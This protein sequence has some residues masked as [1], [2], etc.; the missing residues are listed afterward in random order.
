LD[1]I[2]AQNLDLGKNKAAALEEYRKFLTKHTASPR[3]PEVSEKI[4][5]LLAN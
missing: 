5:N 2:T 3:V 4:A 1:F